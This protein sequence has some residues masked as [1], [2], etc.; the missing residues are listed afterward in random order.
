MQSHLLNVCDLFHFQTSS[1]SNT[2]IIIICVVCSLVAIA[3]LTAVFAVYYVKSKNKRKFNFT[4][5][6]RVQQYILGSDSPVC[7]GGRTANQSRSNRD[8]REK[9]LSL[10]PGDFH[11][12][13]AS[14]FHD[15]SI[16]AIKTSNYVTV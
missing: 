11:L 14:L 3:I 4:L 6:Q 2:D 5:N 13:L 15:C 16:Y 7:P 12:L 8:D 1:L 10:L 9:K